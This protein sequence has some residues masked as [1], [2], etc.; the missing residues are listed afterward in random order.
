VDP[1]TV[2]IS[3]R[4]EAFNEVDKIKNELAT[5][6]CFG[7]VNITSANLDRTGNKVQFEITIERKR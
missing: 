7:P 1:E 2:R 4:T 6:K 5:A 3:G